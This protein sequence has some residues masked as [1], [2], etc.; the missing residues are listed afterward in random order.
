MIYVPFQQDHSGFLR[1]VAFVARAATPP[2]GVVEGI[3]AEIRQAATDLDVRPL[4]IDGLRRDA[5]PP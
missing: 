3:R 1:F 2:A 5:A 4:R